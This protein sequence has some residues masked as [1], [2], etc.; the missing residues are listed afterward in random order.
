MEYL[1]AE[2][3]VSSLSG[4]ILKEIM[5]ADRRLVSRLPSSFIWF[6]LRQFSQ[7]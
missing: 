2:V 5:N 3:L 4:N 6:C 7:A 1:S